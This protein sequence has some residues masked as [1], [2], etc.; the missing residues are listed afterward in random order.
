MRTNYDVIIIGSGAGG[1]TLAYKLAPSGKR[2]LLLERGGFLPREKD[3]WSTAAVFTNG[4]Y[5]A[6]EDWTAKD[7]TIFHPGIHYYVGGNTKVFGAA[8]LR[9]RENDFKELKHAGGISPAWPISYGDLEPF[10]GEAEELYAVHGRFGLD[11]TE[12]PSSRPY[13]HPPISHEPRIRKLFDDLTRMGRRPFN[14][15]VGVHLNEADPA[16]SAC[17][18]CNTCDGFPCLVHAKSDAEVT[19]VRPA[20]E[21]KNVELITG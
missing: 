14:L 4:K 11:P 8:L 6:H 1:G 16:H 5:K 18:R 20:L 7:G 3:N 9:F 13:S 17:I 19:A 21:H 2:V 10:Y 12:G 15:P